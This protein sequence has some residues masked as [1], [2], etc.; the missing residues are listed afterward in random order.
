MIYIP[1]III[2][3]LFLYLNYRIVN[4]D[5]KEKKIPN[6]YLGYLIVIVPFYYIF[7]FNFY[8]LIPFI[9]LS[10]VKILYLFLQIFLTFFVSFIL[11]YFWIWSA[12][13][14]KYLLVLSLFI[15]HIWVISFIGNLAI[16]VLTYMFLYFIRFYLG[17]CIFQKWYVKSL[18]YQIKNDL[19][20]RWKIYKNNKW[21]KS[22]SI[23]LKWLVVFLLIFVSIRLSRVYLF[24]SLK[25]SPLNPLLIGEGNIFEKYHFYLIFA[26]V[27][28][29]IGWLYLFKFLVVRIKKY[30][31]NRLK[32][33]L[34]LVWNVFLVILFIILLGFVFYEYIKNP[35]EILGYL[36]LIFTLYIWIYIIFRVLFYAYKITFH[37]SEMKF[38][39][40]RDLKEGDIVDKEYLVKMLGRQAILWYIE[41]NEK[42]KKKKNYLLY[43]NPWL[44]F[45]KISNPI[46]KE[47]SLLIKKSFSLVNNHHIEKKTNWFMKI[48][49]LKILRTFSFAP[50]IVASFVITFIFWN[51][52]ISYITKLF[53]EIFESEFIK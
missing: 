49:N 19:W 7:I 1:I 23:I 31:S 20:D 4:S 11:Y 15:P 18:F 5:L 42:E 14:A 44:Y 47:T 10:H 53:L 6:I 38:I 28:I 30:L 33:R 41:P 25:T 37:I 13:D 29:F 17:R 52:I 34:D 22:L 27:G 24:D 50:Y 9:D 40:I 26:L 46:D 36:F 12:W 16:I 35:S 21:W 3:V 39:N 8:N 51:S 45:S 48:K 32:L 43:P 2:V